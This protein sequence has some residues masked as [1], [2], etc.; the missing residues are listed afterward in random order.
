MSTYKRS[1][2]GPRFGQDVSRRIHRVACAMPGP[3]IRKV[4]PAEFLRDINER[5]GTSY[6]TMADYQADFARRANPCST[7]ALIEGV[8]STREIRTGRLGG[9]PGGRKTRA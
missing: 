9:M 7:S 4:K 3:P 8:I 2:Y 1:P 5:E 6:N